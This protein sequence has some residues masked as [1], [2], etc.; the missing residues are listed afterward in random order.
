MSQTRI[1]CK[2][3]ENPECY[4]TCTPK[5][6]WEDRITP[7]LQRTW[8]N[9]AGYYDWIGFIRQIL[10]EARK[11]ERERVVTEFVEW[12]KLHDKSH[13]SGD[14]HDCGH[15]FDENGGY[16]RALTDLLAFV[17]SLKKK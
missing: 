14:T 17:D 12:A 16:D 4:C 2:V 13:L 1:L 15:R 11:K 10:A 9:N 5:Q 8:D 6:G 7:L 3:C